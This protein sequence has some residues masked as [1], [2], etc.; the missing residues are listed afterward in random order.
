MKFEKSQDLKQVY[1]R[2]DLSFKWFWKLSHQENK[3]FCQLYM[4]KHIFRGIN[5]KLIKCIYFE[6]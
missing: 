2:N 4:V 1:R 3:Y 5:R 6:I